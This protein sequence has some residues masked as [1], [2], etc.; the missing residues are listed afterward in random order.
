MTA[1]MRRDFQHT[2]RH[3]QRWHLNLIAI[4]ADMINIWHPIVIRAKYAGLIMIQQCGNAAGMIIVV[5]G[6]QNV[7]EVKPALL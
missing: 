2:E 1:R 4:P 5:V 7:A 3:V 6:E